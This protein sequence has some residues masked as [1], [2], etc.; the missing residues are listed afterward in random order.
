MGVFRI[1]LRIDL[2]NVRNVRKE[3]MIQI[4]VE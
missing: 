1:V 4:V 2:I 3:V